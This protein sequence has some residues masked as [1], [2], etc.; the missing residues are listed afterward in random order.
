MTVPTRP[1]DGARS[2]ADVPVRGTD[3]GA[4]G[5]VPGLGAQLPNADR[6]YLTAGKVA[7][8]TFVDSVEVRSTGFHITAGW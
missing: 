3:P 1:A 7:R 5:P 8:M 6:F 2:V 4:A